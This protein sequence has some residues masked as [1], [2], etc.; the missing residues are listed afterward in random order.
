MTRPQRAFALNAAFT[1][2]AFAVSATTQATLA[3]VP[4]PL[5]PHLINHYS[6][7]E[8]LGGSVTSLVEVDLGSDATNLELLNGA[9]RVADGAWG[10]SQYSLQTGQRDTGPNDDWK[11]GVQFGSSSASTLTGLNGVAAVTLAGWF[12]PLGDAT[13]NPSPNTNTGNPT[14]RYN[15]FG[16]FGFLN[17]DDGG[18]NIDG[19]TVR[20]L[21]EVIDGKVTALG[22]RLDSQ[23]A[24]GRRASVESWDDVMPPETWTHLA[25]TFDFDTGDILLFKNGVL[26]DA[27]DPNVN[28]WQL[29]DGPD[30]TS[31]TNSG[32]IKIGGS[33]PNNLA[34]QNPF[35]GRTDELMAFDKALSPREMFD[36]YRAISSPAG[37]YNHD[38]FVDAADYTL[39]RDTK[40]STEDL[41]ADGD[42]SRVVD[43]GDYAVWAN[44]WSGAS[45]ARSARAEVT[46]T[47]EPTALGLAALLLLT[48]PIGHGRRRASREARRPP[49]A[50]INAAARGI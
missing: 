12:K 44:H 34:E 18:A 6:F 3:G 15:A 17:G 49:T 46:S 36:L 40:G 50:P 23:S 22:R 10:G 9:P 4:A 48:T 39:W 37:D 27:G 25:A 16:L 20:A 21:I 14:D 29:T 2:G 47:P 43:D 11:A 7:D 5:L 8:P 31:A 13:D 26:L 19:H 33:F 30:R 42:F 32:G 45:P 38:G 41:R 1:V 24:S 28:A 35:N